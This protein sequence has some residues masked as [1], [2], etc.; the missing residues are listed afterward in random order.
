MLISR[1]LSYQISFVCGSLMSNE[2]LLPNNSLREVKSI[3][4]S[5]WIHV[6]KEHERE[7]VRQMLKTNLLIQKPVLLDEESWEGFRL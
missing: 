3:S 2:Q 4:A 7:Q 1:D 6:I 5:P